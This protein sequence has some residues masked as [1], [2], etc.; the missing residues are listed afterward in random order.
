MNK[1][2][3][4][5]YK[6]IS[7]SYIRELFNKYKSCLLIVKEGARQ[8]V[9][10]EYDKIKTKGGK[11]KGF[12]DEVIKV[13]DAEIYVKEIDK[14]LQKLPGMYQTIMI[15][16]YVRDVPNIQIYIDLGLPERTFYYMK[17]EAIKMFI[18]EYIT[19]KLI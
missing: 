8:Q 6:G 17:D 15:Q 11:V 13:A 9:T 14:I 5:I 19:N 3:R 12:E 10:H 18:D 1:N 4:G 16:S 7:R 2:W